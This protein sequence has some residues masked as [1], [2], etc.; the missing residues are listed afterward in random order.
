MSRNIIA[1]RYAKAFLKVDGHN[2]D[3]ARRRLK[4]L[5][6][7]RELF[8][9]EDA[10]K[11]LISPVMPKE[12]K[13]A[14]LEYA[15]TKAEDKELVSE[16]LKVILEA[17]RVAVIPKIIDTY[18]LYI[19]HLAGVVKTKIVT[20]IELSEEEQKA[21]KTTIEEHLKNTIELRTDTDPSILGG[22][23]AYF[24]NMM[25]DFSLK[26]KVDKLTSSVSP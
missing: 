19:N 20:A 12:L 18:E 4:A 2:V 11:V 3:L 21:F 7:I 5:V 10:K 13:G 16:F 26:S 25:A 23:V 17:N 9:I 15:V 6:N 24:G 8:S 14:L 22:F 1:S